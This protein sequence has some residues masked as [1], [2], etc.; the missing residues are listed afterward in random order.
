MGGFAG[1]FAG[2]GGAVRSVG[3]PGLPSIATLIVFGGLR[4]DARGGRVAPGNSIA[5]RSMSDRKRSAVLLGGKG[6]SAQMSPRLNRPS[7][8]DRTNPSSAPSAS[9]SREVLSF[10]APRTRGTSV[11]GPRPEISKGTPSSY[12]VSPR[13]LPI[14]KSVSEADVPKSPFERA[15]DSRPDERRPNAVLPARRR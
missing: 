2:R 3:S 4:S 14:S 7:I 13:P 5:P 8:R 9:A 1:G 15:N 10:T 6:T 11:A 12:P